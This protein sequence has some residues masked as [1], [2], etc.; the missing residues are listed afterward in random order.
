MI[1]P[2]EL[3]QALRLIADAIER[4][5]SAERLLTLEQAGERLGMAPEQVRRE[6]SDELPVIRINARTLRVREVSLNEWCRKREALS[7]RR[8]RI[9]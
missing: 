1:A 6:L 2:L 4:E 5:G 8:L 9:A 3:A 7:R